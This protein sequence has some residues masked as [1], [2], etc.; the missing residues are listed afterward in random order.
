MNDTQDRIQAC[1]TPA[2]VERLIY[3]I[4]SAS[5]SEAKALVSRALKLCKAEAEAEHKASAKLVQ[6]AASWLP[7]LAKR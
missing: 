1:K 4:S 3:D 6:L 5:R 7:S 2:D